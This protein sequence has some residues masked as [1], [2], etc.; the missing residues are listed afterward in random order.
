VNTLER[1]GL[2]ASERIG[3]TRL[4]YANDQSPFFED[5]RSLLLKAF[6]PTTLLAS[7]LRRVPR[8]ES[9]FIYGSWARQYEGLDVA[10]PRDVDVL[11]VG[12][13]NPNA[14]YAAA[15]RAEDEL[16]LEVNPLIVSIEEWEQPRGIVRR[17]KEGPLVPLLLGDAA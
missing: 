13:P 14:V 5:L 16:D 6:G 11:V 10:P 8:I 2:V 4:V 17:V 15:R 1:A 12:E 7:L 9:A 3:N